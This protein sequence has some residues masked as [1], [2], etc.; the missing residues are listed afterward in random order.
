MRSPKSTDWR[1][2]N[3]RRRVEVVTPVTDAT[4]RARLDAIL[5]AQLADPHAWRL[6]GDGSYERTP[7]AVGPS[8][9]DQFMQGV[10]VARAPA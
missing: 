2:R 6:L 8:A 5:E 9:Q 1:S 4:A 3:L 10:E 7:G